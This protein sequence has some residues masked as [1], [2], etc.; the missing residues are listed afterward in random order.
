MIETK[1]E[2]LVSGARAIGQ[3]LIVELAGG[4]RYITH[5]EIY[6]RLLQIVLMEILGLFVLPRGDHLD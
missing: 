1:N 4:W 6:E 2:W 3:G 5:N